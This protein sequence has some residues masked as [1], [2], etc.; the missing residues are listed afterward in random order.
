M[1]EFSEQDQRSAMIMDMERILNPEWFAK[2]KTANKD[3]ILLSPAQYWDWIN[4]IDV[5]CPYHKV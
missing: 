4:Y 3:A 1:A 2:R 5:S